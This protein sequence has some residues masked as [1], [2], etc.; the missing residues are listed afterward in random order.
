[1]G[2]I[3]MSQRG[4]PP[5]NKAYHHLLQLFVATSPR[6]S[7]SR[8]FK[9][10]AIYPK[11]VFYD[12][13]Q[14]LL[15]LNGFSTIT[16]GDKLLCPMDIPFV[17]HLMNRYM[18]GLPIVHHANLL[19]YIVARPG[20]GFHVQPEP[21]TTTVLIPAKNERG[22][23]R[24]AIRRTPKMGPHTEIIFVEGGSEDGTREEILTA[25]KEEQSDCEIRF[26]PQPGKGKGDAVKAGFAQ[27]KGDVLMILDA[28]LTVMPEDLPRF[29]LALAEGRGEFINGCRLVYPM[30]DEAMRLLNW[31][32]IKCLG[33]P[34][35]L[36]FN[37]HSKTRYAA[38]RYSGVP[39]MKKYNC[40]HL[41]E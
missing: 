29:Y 28:D 11:L 37:N 5:R 41:F 25:M 20:T 17:S 38:R 35:L 24:P 34:F 18:A 40:R 22:N 21:L 32:P 14:Q 16:Q 19:Q 8:W 39:I 3:Q 4:L 6:N 10:T 30:E 9:A 27:A 23:I 15:R 7:A 31:W 1:M 36:F 26:I 13:Y 12:R 33:W 2:G